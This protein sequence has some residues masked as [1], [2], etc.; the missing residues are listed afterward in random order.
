MKTENYRTIN[1]TESPNNK[2]WGLLAKV[3]GT[4][5]QI[6]LQLNDGKSYKYLTRFAAKEGDVAIVGNAF[7]QNYDPSEPMATT[8]QMG[9]ATEVLDKAAIKKNHAGEMDFVFTPQMDKKEVQNCV[10]Y[11]CMPTDKKNYCYNKYVGKCYPIT[12]LI[13]RV[14]SAATVLAFDEYSKDEDQAF[15]KE[16]ILSKHVFEDDLFY[17]V[18]SGAPYG[19]A[20]SLIDVHIDQ[21]DKPAKYLDSLKIGLKKGC[22][23]TDGALRSNSKLDDYINKYVNMG[24]ISIMVRGGFYNLLKAYLSTGINIEA[25]KN[26]LIDGL[27]DCGNKDALQLLES[28]PVVDSIPQETESKKKKSSTK[29]FKI[30]DEKL[31]A[32]SGKDENVVIPDGVKSIEDGA[33]ENNDIISSIVIPSTVKKIGKD[34]FS[35]CYNLSRVVFSEGL[36]TIGRNA[37]GYCKKIESIS[38]PKSLKTIGIS[39]FFCCKINAITLGSNV[40]TVGKNAFGGCSLKEVHIQGAD[41]KFNECS[42]GQNADANIFVY[43][44]TI[45]LN[46]IGAYTYST[47]YCHKGSVIEQ[48]LIQINEKFKDYSRL[49]QYKIEY[50]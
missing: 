34:A 36:T 17:N 39:S 15:A 20:L 14:L 2:E 50:F 21:G 8:G 38:L 19:S 10:K 41:T 18:D 23:E 33:F 48:D 16:Y 45:S 9:I 28:C 30:V 47:Y 32:Y 11:L 12:Y 44:D 22:L 25:Y 7:L 35:R 5:Q 26:E 6:E 46:Q 27:S 43:S 37:F 42:L 49:S 24:A 29:E 13:R 3:L 31:V 40:K 4:L 1:T